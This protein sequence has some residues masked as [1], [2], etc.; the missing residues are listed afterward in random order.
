V[1]RIEQAR[2]DLDA[3][4]AKYEESLAI[5]R[6]LASELGTPGS[7]RDVSISLVRVARIEQARGDLDAALAKYEE[8][9]GIRREL[10]SELGTPGSEQDLSWSLAKIA[11][12]E[13]A[14]GNPSKA[15]HY[16][17][18]AIVIS[19]HLQAAAPCG[20]SI[21]GRAQHANPLVWDLVGLARIQLALGALGAAADCL[22]EA[23]ELVA[24]LEHPDLTDANL[25]DTAAAFYETQAKAAEAS[26]DGKLARS[27]TKAAAALR[28]R[29]AAL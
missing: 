27:A 3:A 28:A 19:R 11:K 26:G 12:L 7:R 2:G 13:L 15:R 25:L 18:E 1:A 5:R 6:E 10:A 20:D 4:L 17:E 8:S 23:G 29:I 14:R 22:A 24:L 21:L 16:Q 9:L